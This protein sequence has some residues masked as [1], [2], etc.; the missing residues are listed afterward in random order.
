[1]NYICPKQEMVSTKI[2]NNSQVC[3]IG[4]WLSLKK[5]MG[6]SKVNGEEP[7]AVGLKLIFSF[8][9]LEANLKF[10]TWYG[11]ICSLNILKH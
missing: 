5:Y 8:K 10:N 9:H 7:F 1:M 3:L 4:K 6:N 2:K 11:L